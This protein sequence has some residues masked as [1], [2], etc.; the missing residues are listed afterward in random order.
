MKQVLSVTLALVC[1]VALG[2]SPALAD[3]SG[4]HKRQPRSHRGGGTVHNVSA[5]GGPGV[6]VSGVAGATM[7]L[8]DDV[9]PI[10]IAATS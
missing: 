3:T 5:R 8:G 2:V 4:V 9:N 6:H 10:A 1:A 7:V